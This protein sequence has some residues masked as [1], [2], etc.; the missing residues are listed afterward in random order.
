VVVDNAKP[1]TLVTL[2]MHRRRHSADGALSGRQWHKPKAAATGDFFPKAG[3]H[4]AGRVHLQTLSR[5]QE[6]WTET[7][8]KGATEFVS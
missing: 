1:V 2:V 3:R 5:G 6:L 8:M 4:G 7:E